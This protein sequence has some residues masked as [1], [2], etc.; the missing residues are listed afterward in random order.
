MAEDLPGIDIESVMGRYKAIPKDEEEKAFVERLTKEAVIRSVERHAGQIR[1]IYGPSGRSTVAEGKDLTQ[2][3][4]IVGTGGALTRLPHRVDIMKE[5]AKH[6]ETG[7]LL[8]PSESAKILVDNDYIM[9]SLGVLSKRYKEAT[10]KLLE[11]SLDF[12]FPTKE[13]LQRSTKAAYMIEL[14]RIEAERKEKEKREEEHRK[15]LKEQGYE[16]VD[17]EYRPIQS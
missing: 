6:N 13:E 3:K 4:Y 1:Y 16:L 9:A 2:V 5:I 7:L 12:H 15:H 17:G 10:I 14:E 11:K 8:F